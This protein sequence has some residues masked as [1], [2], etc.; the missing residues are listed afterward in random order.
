MR[1]LLGELPDVVLD[2][3]RQAIPPHLEVAPRMRCQ[4]RQGR[5]NR[6]DLSPALEATEDR[7]DGSAGELMKGQPPGSNGPLADR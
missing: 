2:Q 7:Q 1:A 4:G 6:H 5:V 3:T